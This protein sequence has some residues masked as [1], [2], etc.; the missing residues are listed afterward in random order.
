[1]QKK[2]LILDLGGV[3]LDIDYQRTI[4]AFQAL[5]IPKANELYSQQVQNPVFDLLEKG[6]IDEMDFYEEIRR[7]SRLELSNDVIRKCWNAILIGLPVE[8]TQ[9]LYELKKKYRLFLLSN[10]NAIHEQAYRQMIIDQYG[11]FVFDGIFEKMYLSHRIHLRK[12]DAEIFHFVIEDAQ[13]NLEDTLFIDDSI[14]H[15]EGAKKAGLDALLMP[16]NL[17]LGQFLEKEISF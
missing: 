3:I 13:L 9:T 14:Q 11:E 6:M 15:V 5:G 2:N 16:K 8:N 17:L 1:M 12:P 10:T 4:N 7:I